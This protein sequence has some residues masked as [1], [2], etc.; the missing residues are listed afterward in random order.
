VKR[1]FAFVCFD[2]EGDA[3]HGREAANRAI[4]DLHDKEVDGFKLYVQQA[5]PAEQRQ[6]QVLRDQIRFKNSK[7]KCNL[8]VKNFPAS[9]TKDRLY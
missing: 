5:I 7:K 1:P 4:S 8:F 3:I 2:K 6:A 9:Y